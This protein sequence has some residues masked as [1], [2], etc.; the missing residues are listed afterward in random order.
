[1]IDLGVYDVF[2]ITSPNDPQRVDNCTYELLRFALPPRDFAV[3]QFI[4][5]DLHE[6]YLALITEDAP[7]A[8]HNVRTYLTG[9]KIPPNITVYSTY[10]LLELQKN[11]SVGSM[12]DGFQVTISSFKGQGKYNHSIICHI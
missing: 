11:S 7:D 3:L 2:T 10:F 4:H 1:M 8:D 9:N 6:D 5:L 12:T